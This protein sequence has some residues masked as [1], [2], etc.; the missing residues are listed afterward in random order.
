MISDF[1][2]IKSILNFYHHILF[3]TAYYNFHTIKSI[4]NY[5][6][7]DVRDNYWDKFPYY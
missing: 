5:E 7:L 4:L 2:T 6:P 1:H 3:C